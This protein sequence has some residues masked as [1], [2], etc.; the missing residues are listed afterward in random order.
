MGGA[1]LRAAVLFLLLHLGASR[2]TGDGEPPGGPN[3][4]SLQFNNKQRYVVRRDAG[5][6]YKSFFLYVEE[7]HKT[8]VVYPLRYVN[9]ANCVTAPPLKDPPSKHSAQIVTYTRRE[10]KG[11]NLKQFC[12]EKKNLH[13]NLES[14]EVCFCC[15][16]SPHP[17][18]PLYSSLKYRRQKVLCRRRVT[19]GEEA[20]VLTLKC[21]KKSKRKYHAFFVQRGSSSFLIN[22]TL[23][24]FNLYDEFFLRRNDK[25]ALER[26]TYLLDPSNSEIDDE[27][28][29]VRL[30]FLAE[31]T[32]RGDSIE[33]DYLFLDSDV[34]KRRVV[35]DDSFADEEVLENGLIVSA[36]HVDEKGAECNKITE[37]PRVWE[38]RRGFC[39]NGK[40]HCLKGQLAHFASLEGKLDGKKRLRHNY[41]FFMRR[42]ARL[43]GEAIRSSEES[44]ASEE[45]RST[46]ANRA[47]AAN[48]STA[49]T[50]PRDLEGDYHLG[51]QKRAHNFAVISSHAGEGLQITHEED[52]HGESVSLVHLLS[53]CYDF[54]NEVDP[55]CSVYISIWN[56]EGV[57][58]DVS[59]SIECSKR[60]VADESTLRR[61]VALAQKGESSVVI[62]FKPIADLLVT[63]CRVVVQRQERPAELR[64]QKGNI[65]GET[66]P[67][68]ANQPHEPNEQYFA[69]SLGSHSETEEAPGKTPGRVIWDS[70]LQFDEVPGDVIELHKRRLQLLEEEDDGAAGRGGGALREYTRRMA[71]YFMGCQTGVQVFLLLLCIILVVI[72]IIPSVHPLN[73]FLLKRKWFYTLKKIRI[74]AIWKVQDVCLFLFRRVKGTI[75]MLKFILVKVCR[76]RR[77]RRNERGL[78]GE[79]YL[80]KQTRRRKRDEKRR[81]K[82]I[83]G[84]KLK[85]E[86]EELRRR[87]HRRLRL[88]EEQCRG[89]RRHRDRHGRGHSKGGDSSKAASAS[90]AAASVS[91]STSSAS[92]AAERGRKKERARHAS[93]RGE[94]GKT[95]REGTPPSGDQERHHRAGGKA[96]TSRSPKGVAE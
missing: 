92:S 50:P 82:K 60:I 55:S 57:E 76:G 43:G 88:H 16:C 87:R 64:P 66:P 12:E 79:A 21:L 70:P 89:G 59:V 4:Y 41:S 24:E 81:K 39:Q 80:H 18:F 96:A 33:G 52:L 42:K 46:E 25:S 5:S 73:G 63:P 85:R 47:T 84:E 17:V 14:G 69:F 23:Q 44:H 28:F 51:L 7:V 6:P 26:R 22:I 19:D 49:A 67:N 1:G 32:H 54:N 83:K 95:H 56:A 77:K 3:T 35:L 86:Q 90:S 29:N 15:H 48:R 20:V 74:L 71:N 62:T 40:S 38:E 9:Q 11:K 91:S 10:T 34:F 31:R 65:R 45:N 53:N 13:Q 68:K 30:K 72:F 8:S 93:R 94:G 75:K 36:D 2:T 78:I 61:R 37:Y 58:K 27:V